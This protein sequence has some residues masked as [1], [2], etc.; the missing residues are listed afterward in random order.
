MNQPLVQATHGEDA[1]KASV[2]HMVAP[3]DPLRLSLLQERQQN[4]QLRQDLS[5][6]QAALAQALADLAG[7]QAGERQARHLAMHDGLTALPNRRFFGERLAQALVHSDPRRPGPAVL[8]LDLDDFKP[9]NDAHGHAAG[10]ELLK[11]VAA[12][13][14]GTVRAGDMV[15]RLGGDEFA[16]LREEFPGH[17]KLCR[18]ACKLFDAVSAPVRIGGLRLS[19]RPSIGIAVGPT[20]GDTAEMLL[21]NADLAMY[22]AKR[23]KTGYAFFNRCSDPA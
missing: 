6:A 11:I 9:I 4:Q 23:Q 14:A 18:L 19:V 8:F 16:C 15:S 22:R 2:L 21:R 13:L 5:D 7:T 3:A 17:D 10:D 12:R 1:D 20:D